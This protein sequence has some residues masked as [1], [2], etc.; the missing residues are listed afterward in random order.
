MYVIFPTILKL[1]ERATHM[2]E[3]KNIETEETEVVETES[4][5][6]KTQVLEKLDTNTLIKI[7]NETRF[8]N[9]G[10]RIKEKQSKKEVEK[11]KEQMKELNKKYSETTK[12][13]TAEEE[14]KKV[15]TLEKA[16]EFEKVTIQMRELAEA[17]ENYQN[18]LKEQTTII[19]QL[20]TKTS[21]LERNT[22]IDS[23]TAKDNI[24]WS[25][26]FERMGFVSQ[27][28]E[29]KDGDFV[30]DDEDIENAIKTLKHVKYVAPLTP[31]TG[32]KEK[33]TSQPLEM[34]INNI[35]EKSTKGI[36]LSEEEMN[37]LNRFQMG[38]TG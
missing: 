18:Q 15:E 8:E 36:R 24:Q 29:F 22:K 27:F 38:I 37:K 35:I 12:T 33:A 11:L 4:P 10:W 5:E 30:H 25:S 13:L 3:E 23:M 31:G 14:R 1:T 32:P 28:S 21:L 17:K 6:E 19:E 7:I 16:G 26:E 9:G 20:K 34:E 2:S